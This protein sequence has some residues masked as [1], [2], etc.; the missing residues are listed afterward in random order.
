M[1]AGVRAKDSQ[2]MVARYAADVLAFDL[3]EPPQYRGREE[4]KHRADEWLASW[5]GPLAF[6][7]RDLVFSTGGQSAF[8]H[9]LNR[10]AGTKTHGAAVDMRWRATTGFPHR[11]GAWVVTHLHSSIPFDLMTGKASLGLKPEAE[12]ARRVKINKQRMN[13]TKEIR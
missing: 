3:I 13:T 12:H 5:R 11:D 6:E 7:M 1:S 2:A 10:V 9:S 8:C 4:V